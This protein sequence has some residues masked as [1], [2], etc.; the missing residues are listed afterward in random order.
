MIMYVW[1]TRLGRASF[2]CFCHSVIQPGT[3]DLLE[4]S[5]LWGKKGYVKHF[6]AHLHTRPPLIRRSSFSNELNPG[7]S[8]GIEV[9][10]TTSLVMTTEFTIGI[11]MVDDVAFCQGLVA[12]LS[13]QQCKRRVALFLSSLQFHCDKSAVL[14]FL[15]TSV[16]LF[17]N[18][19]KEFKG[20]WFIQKNI[21]GNSA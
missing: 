8:C 5:S 14:I 9:I 20:L 16:R 3:V 17:N 12:F 11:V 19:S 13:S 4:T 18:V 6:R 10:I 15:P 7:S 2:E 21:P 1:G